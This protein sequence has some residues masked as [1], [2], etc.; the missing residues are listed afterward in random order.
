MGEKRLITFS[1][2]KHRFAAPIDEIREVVSADAVMPVPGARRPLLGLLPYRGHTV[3]PVF[4]L[5]DLLGDRSGESGNLVIVAASPGGPVG[6][7]VRQMGG[8]MMLS[9]GEQEVV[10]YEGDLGAGTGAVTALL[11]RTGGEYIILDI[12]KLFTS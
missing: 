10:P 4:S 11:K 1:I 12:G 3:L 6:F 2:S 8:V 7:R 5:L 9:A